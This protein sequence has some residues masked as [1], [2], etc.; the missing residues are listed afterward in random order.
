MKKILILFAFVS[1]AAFGQSYFAH[2]GIGLGSNAVYTVGSVGF[3]TLSWAVYG[4]SALGVRAVAYPGAL[5]AGNGAMAFSNGVAVGKFAVAGTNAIAIGYEAVSGPLRGV[6]LGSGR[7]TNDLLRVYELTLLDVFGYIPADRIPQGSGGFLR[8]TGNGSLESLHSTASGFNSRAEGFN[9]LAT[10]A[11][12]HSAGVQT[13]ANGGGSHSEGNLANAGGDY[14][15]AEG[16]GTTAS[17]TASHAEGLYT[18]ASGT[19]S[20]AEGYHTTAS[21]TG[22]KAVGAYTTASGDYSFAAG[23]IANASNFNSFV[24]AYYNVAAPIG[25][26]SHGEGTFNIRPKGDASG[27]WIGETNLQAH[28][29]ARVAVSGGTATNLDISLSEIVL[30]G[31]TGSVTLTNRAERPIRATGTGAVSLAFAGFKNARPVYLQLG[32]F[33]AVAWPSGTYALGGWGE[34]QTNQLNHFLVWSA[35]TNLFVNALTTSE[36]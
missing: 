20:H 13:S 16:Q 34:W 11:N 7:N 3:G 6:Q 27:F 24:W 2:P 28:L 23:Y 29:D 12:S 9:T 8:F 14:S 10:G 1:V 31:L 21:G 30:E 19:G 15:H 22:A 26:G 25:Y 17:G 32:G 36:L 4:G 35:G 5:A 18:T 33:D